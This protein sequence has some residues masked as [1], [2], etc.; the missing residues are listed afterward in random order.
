VGD[1]YHGEEESKLWVEVDDVAVGED[2]LRL[3]FL[4]GGEHDGDLLRGD[5]QHRQVDTVELV[6]TAPR[7]GLR[8]TYA[9]VQ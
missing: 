9:P 6:E 7:P 2:E 3:V 5:R 1:Y 8:Q 4:L